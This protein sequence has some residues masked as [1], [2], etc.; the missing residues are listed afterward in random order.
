MTFLEDVEEVCFVV[1]PTGVVVVFVVEEGGGGG[2]DATAVAWSVISGIC[3][4][5]LL[6]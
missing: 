4:W 1:S 3:W 2:G 5:G 6:M